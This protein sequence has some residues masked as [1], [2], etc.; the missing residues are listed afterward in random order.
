MEGSGVPN[1]AS[2]LRRAALLVS[3]WRLLSASTERSRARRAASSG[4]LL[5]VFSSS[6]MGASTSSALTSLSDMAVHDK[7]PLLCG[8]VKPASGY[9][10]RHFR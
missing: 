9:A 3:S 2:N 1:S 8:F 4:I 6:L 5:A 7:G 10:A